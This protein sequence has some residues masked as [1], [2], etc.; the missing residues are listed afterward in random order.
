MYVLWLSLVEVRGVVMVRPVRV[1]VTNTPPP[2]WLVTYL[3]LVGCQHDK[4]I[5]QHNAVCLFHILM[6]WPYLQLAKPQNA[7]ATDK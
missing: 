1:S 4:V 6:H 7:R 3:Y 2:A 5:T